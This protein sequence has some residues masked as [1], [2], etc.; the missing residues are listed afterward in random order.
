MRVETTGL[1]I[2]VRDRIGLDDALAS[3]D[4]A[5]P[6]D[7]D[8]RIAPMLLD[9]EPLLARFVILYDARGAIAEGRIHVAAPQIERLEN[10]TVRVDNVVSAC[11]WRP[12]EAQVAS[13]GGYPKPPHLNII[14]NA[15]CRLMLITAIGTFR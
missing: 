8:P 11:H 10:V 13:L 2:D 7:V 3:P 1:A 6:A 14:Q 4:R 9:D 12:S 5:D 15:E